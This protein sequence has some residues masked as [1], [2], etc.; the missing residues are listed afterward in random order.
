MSDGV[1]GSELTRL[2]A[3]SRLVEALERGDPGCVVL[4]PPEPLDGDDPLEPAAE[5]PGEPSKQAGRIRGHPV[6]QVRGVLA[7]RVVV[8]TELDPFLPLRALAGY[9]G[10]SVRKLRDYLEDPSHPLPHYRVGGKIVVRRSEFDAWMGRYHQ[11]GRADVGRIVSEV[12]EEFR[13]VGRLS[14]TA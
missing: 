13:P 1:H 4:S 2:P 10:L 9:S 11:V 6:G 14:T 5:T 7:E 12:F 8:G 3:L